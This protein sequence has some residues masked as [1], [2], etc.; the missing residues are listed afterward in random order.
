MKELFDALGVPFF[1]LMVWVGI[2][3]AVAAFMKCMAIIG[4]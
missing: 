1:V 4:G 2:L 3:V